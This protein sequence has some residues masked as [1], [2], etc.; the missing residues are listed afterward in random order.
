M[1]NRPMD[2]AELRLA[3][4]AIVAINE[5]GE[6]EELKAEIADVCR[7]QDCPPSVDE[8]LRHRSFNQRCTVEWLAKELCAMLGASCEA[9]LEAAA[10]VVLQTRR[11]IALDCIT[12]RAQQLARQREVYQ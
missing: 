10:S 3:A 12:H 4:E 1:S 8:L 11:Q 9:C 5:A 2:Q 6:L 7:D